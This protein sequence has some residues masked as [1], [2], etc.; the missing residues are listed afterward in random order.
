[1]L[2]KK[3]FCHSLI[4]KEHCHFVL[5]WLMI[6]VIDNYRL[7]SIG[8]PTRYKLLVLTP[9]GVDVYVLDAFK[10]QRSN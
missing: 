2:Q 4:I 1:M 9:G 3:T 8:R 6:A 5:S 10:I 7:S